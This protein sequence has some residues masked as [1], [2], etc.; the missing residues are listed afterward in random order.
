MRLTTWCTDH[1]NII[2]ENL[3]FVLMVYDNPKHD[4][5]SSICDR[6]LECVCT[7]IQ[8]DNTDVDQ[9]AVSEEIQ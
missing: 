1:L 7:H 4:E 8:A 2:N 5:V 3:V 9:R 6:N